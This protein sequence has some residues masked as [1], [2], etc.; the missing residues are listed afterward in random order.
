MYIMETRWKVF[1]HKDTGTKYD[2][3]VPKDLH[4]PIR[5][6][7]VGASSSGKS[8]L[9][10]NLV[11]EDYSMYF[12]EVVLFAGTEKTLN[13]YK[14]IHKH[15]KPP[16]ELRLIRGYNDETAMRIIDEIEKKK[17]KKPRL[18]IF[19]DLGF[20]NISKKA[21]NN[22]ID[23]LFQTGRHNHLSVFIVAQRYTDLNVSTRNNNSS[24]L[25]VFRIGNNDLKK[26]HEEHGEMDKFDEF[27][28]VYSYALH[29]PY[30]FLLIDK[31]LNEYR[32]RELKPVELEKVSVP[33]ES[34]LTKEEQKEMEILKAGPEKRKVATM[35]DVMKAREKKRVQKFT[36]DENGNIIIKTRG[37]GSKRLEDKEAEKL[38]KWAS[39]NKGRLKSLFS[40]K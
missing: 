9:C 35:K 2:G 25:F 11:F 8:N 10:K 29:K 20:K 13:E 37:G 32:D 27:K 6:C 4:A 3:M 36:R 14:D 28:K 33:H 15:L 31:H 34:L 24:A 18:F 39:K 30:G 21:K 38:L 5:A 23:R 26:I 17:D 12:K 16:F 1:S 7:F 40:D 19:D 22:Q